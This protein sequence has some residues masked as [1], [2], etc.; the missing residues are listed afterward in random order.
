MLPYTMTSEILLFS[1]LRALGAWASW[2]TGGARPP[3]ARLQGHNQVRRAIRSHARACVPCSLVAQMD[4]GP[5][6]VQIGCL[7][8]QPIREGMRQRGVVPSRAELAAEASAVAHTLNVAGVC[9]VFAKVYKTVEAWESSMAGIH[10]AMDTPTLD[11][12]RL[13]DAM[14]IQW[15]RR[16]TWHSCRRG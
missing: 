2:S 10:A 8:S 4:S 13:N 6:R 3:L 12:L 15:S 9:T 11:S 5:G 1:A 7:R 14:F 16:H